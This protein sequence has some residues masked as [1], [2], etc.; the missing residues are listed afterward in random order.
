M[1]RLVRVSG[2]VAAALF[3]MV[4]AAAAHPLG[5]F[6][7]NHL[8]RITSAGDTVAI[9]YVLDMAE[10]PAF[11]LDRSLDAARYAVARDADGMG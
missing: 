4:S 10:I 3:A 2:M 1:R 7:V 6:T 5:N 11:A 8:S 9:R